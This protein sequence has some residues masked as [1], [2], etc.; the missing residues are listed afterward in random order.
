MQSLFVCLEKQYAILKDLKKQRI[1]ACAGSAVQGDEDN[2]AIAPPLTS[3][4]Y[5]ATT[6]LSGSMDLPQSVNK[7]FSRELLLF[8]N[9]F[10]ILLKKLLITVRL[11]FISEA[12]TFC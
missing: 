3:A 7:I 6:L 2:D 1:A 11:A 9:H 12:R 5:C 10:K 4:L 8:S